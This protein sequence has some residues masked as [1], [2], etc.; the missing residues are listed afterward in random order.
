MQ[1]SPVAIIVAVIFFSCILIITSWAFPLDQVVKLYICQTE[2]DLAEI[3]EW[4]TSDTVK[5]KEATKNGTLTPLDAARKSAGSFVG[6]DKI[7]CNEKNQMM[8]EQLS[9]DGDKKSAKITLIEGPDLMRYCPI[10]IAK[11]GHPCK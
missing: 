6:N 1:K 5:Y 8:I 10:T 3:M 11:H 7:Q 9:A 2:H 4:E